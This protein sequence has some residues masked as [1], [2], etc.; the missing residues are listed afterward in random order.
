MF[1]LTRTRLAFLGI[2]FVILLGGGLFLSWRECS[3][4]TDASPTITH[5][6]STQGL[7][8]SISS[9]KPAL[10]ATQVSVTAGD[11]N[12]VAKAVSS[13][14]LTSHQSADATVT[15]PSP[16]EEN[17]VSDPAPPIPAVYGASQGAVTNAV[18]A[19]GLSDIAEQFNERVKQG[20]W[21]TTSEVYHSNWQKASEEADSQLR[22][23]FGVQAFQQL[24]HESAP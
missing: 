2:V 21:D 7:T 17:P 20:G 13:S 6:I 4:E 8:S 23:R 9:N 15:S 19:D 18:L 24:Q 10:T 1:M 16:T 11:S 5:E 22:A 3:R 12:P 14:S